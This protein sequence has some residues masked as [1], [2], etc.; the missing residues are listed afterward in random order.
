MGKVITL[1]ATAAASQSLSVA[2][3]VDEF[4]ARDW[5]PNTLRSFRSD[6]R[7]FV[8]IFGKCRV[9]ELTSTELQIYLD[10]LARCRKPVGRPL[11]GASCNRHH[12]TLRDLFG[13]LAIAGFSAI[14]IWVVV[15][16]RKAKRAKA[17]RS[18]TAE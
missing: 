10:S 5:P 7:R 3:A 15:R 16:G 13:W 12:G 14:T 8:E 18:G 6:L 9:D 2:D 11:G 4:L 1:T 17:L